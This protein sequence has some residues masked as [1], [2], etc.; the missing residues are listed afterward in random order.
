M[1]GFESLGDGRFGSVRARAES[2]V[3][4]DRDADLSFV[5]LH[6]DERLS[7]S[8]PEPVNAFLA[9]EIVRQVRRRP[10]CRKCIM[11]V[12]VD[13]TDGVWRVVSVPFG[14]VPVDG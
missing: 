7:V 3:A 4:V 13:R 14:V 12:F 11:H 9:L 2:V 8:G 10:R 1:A 5:C 6:V